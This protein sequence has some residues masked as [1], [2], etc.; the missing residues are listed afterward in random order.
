MITDDQVLAM[1]ERADPARTSEANDTIDVTGSL[2][3]L[4]TRSNDM[5]ITKNP[6]PTARRQYAVRW[7]AAAAAAVILVVVGL[8]VLTRDTDPDDP[9]G[10]VPAD[11]PTTVAET[12]PLAEETVPPPQPVPA[13][14]IALDYLAAYA[15]RDPDAVTALEADDFVLRFAYHDG[16]LIEPGEVGFL[17]KLQ[18]AASGVEYAEPDCAIESDAPNETVVSCTARLRLAPHQAAGSQGVPVDATVVV[19][20]EGIRRFDTKHRE[21]TVSYLQAFDDWATIN[22]PTLDDATTTDEQ[23]AQGLLEAECADEWNAFVVDTPV[24]VLADLETGDVDAFLARFA[25]DAPI[26][27]VAAAD[28]EAAFTAFASSGAVLGVRSCAPALVRDRAMNVQ[29]DATIT[30]PGGAEA[31][32]TLT[33]LVGPDRVIRSSETTLDI[34]SV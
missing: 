27:G 21:G 32:G 31:A 34:T 23:I 15:L 3:V 1:F 22:C 30:A 17:S 25:A 5:T 29:C 19:T 20:P 8:I 18:Q 14:E 10:L 33:L 6:P 9:A 26:L 2:D 7:M 16:G 11:Q 4:R 24:D 12:A 13:D 28:A